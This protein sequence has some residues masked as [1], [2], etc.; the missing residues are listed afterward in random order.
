MGILDFLK[1]KK[2]PPGDPQ[3][4]KAGK[5]IISKN[6]DVQGRY[7]AAETLAEIGTDEAI[8][9]L[10][11]RFTTVIGTE[12]PDEDEKKFVR[13]R[14]MRFGKQSIG[15]VMKFLKEK[16]HAGMA[17]EI[18]KKLTSPE[19][20]LDCLLE[21]VNGFDPFFSKYPDKKRQT[22]VVIKEYRDPRI[23]EALIPF[24]DDDDD[25]IRIAVVEALVAQND[26]ENTREVL[27]QTI[28]DS[29][30]CPRVR[31]A[32]CDALANLGWKVKG[33]RKQ[34]SAVLPDQ[35]YLD[36]KGRVLRKRGAGGSGQ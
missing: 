2:L 22:F 30:E 31:I 28:L 26:E 32:A 33:F 9:C 5:R 29:E 34:I 24:L 17:L 21:L 7:G 10:L 12:I 18:L 35:F 4:Q 36:G 1:P 25:D 11:Q 19:E 6:T 14:V 16:E 13:D 3:T 15:P 23:V 20:H 27:L 8:Y